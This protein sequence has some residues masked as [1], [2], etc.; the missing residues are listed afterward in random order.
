MGWTKV[1][2]RLYFCN[3][4]ISV[5][6]FSPKFLLVIFPVD[7]KTTSHIADNV[8]GNLVLQAVFYSKC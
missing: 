1:C 3:C 6:F 7:F 2:Y 4:L 5:D 8:C